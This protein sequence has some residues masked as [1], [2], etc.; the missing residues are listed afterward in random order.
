MG[1]YKSLRQS[2]LKFND[3]QAISQQIASLIKR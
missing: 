1:Y 3:P 2:I